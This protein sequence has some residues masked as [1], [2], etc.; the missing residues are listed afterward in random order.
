MIE[1][2]KWLNL[3]VEQVIEPQ[4]PICDAHIHLRR[5]QSKQYLSADF[6]KDAGH[7]HNIRRS[8]VI[9]SRENYKVGQGGGMTPIEE[10]EFVMK[11]ACTIESR[12]GVATGFIGYADLTMGDAVA[13]VLESQI[14]LGRGR[15]RGIRFS[16]RPGTIEGHDAKSVLSETDFLKGLAK[17]QDYGLTYELV[18]RPNQFEELAE[19]AKKFPDTP[20]IV[21]H[22]GWMFNFGHGKKLNEEQIQEWENSILKLVH[23]NNIYIKLGGLGGSDAGF[24]WSNKAIPPGSAEL[25]SQIAPYYLYCI[26]KFGVK[27][28]MFESNF[29]VDKESYSY[30]VL[31]NAFKRITK[32][33]SYAERFAL[34]YDT[35]AQVYHL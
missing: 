9:Q 25:A 21:N 17:L 13:S 22:I 2:D 5:L 19:L 15:F 14:A 33:F 28:C 8:V 27:R 29:P 3:I 23:C 6:L 18:V 31:W 10:T 7:G 32:A 20:M 24:G 26:E 4:L 30:L 34:F 12:I 35:A 1:H 16:R 11:D